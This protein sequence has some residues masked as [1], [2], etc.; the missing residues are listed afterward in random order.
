MFTILN[1][2]L[3]DDYVHC[4]A[5]HSSSVLVIGLMLNPSS[6][7]V[8]QD[9]L[10]DLIKDKDQNGKWHSREPPRDGKRVHFQ[11]LVHSRCVGEES[12]QDSF[13]EN[14]KVHHIIHHA[15]LEDRVLSGLTNDEISPLYNYNG[16]EE[17]CMACVLQYLSISVGP[18]LAIGVF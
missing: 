16:D 6:R 14:S 7:I 17:S 18:L 1:V 9:P 11:A 5:F 8:S 12:C 13:K 2:K 4:T 3:I 10:S 15:L